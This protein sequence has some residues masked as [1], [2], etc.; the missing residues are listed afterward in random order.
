VLTE[1]LGVK[2]DSVR[3]EDLGR[4]KRVEE[5]LQERLRSCRAESR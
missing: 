5:K 3:L 2:L 1:E 4:A